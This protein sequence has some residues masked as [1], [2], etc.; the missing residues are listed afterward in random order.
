MISYRENLLISTSNI[1][2]DVHENCECTPLEFYCTVMFD[3]FSRRSHY[4]LTYRN[5]TLIHI[6]Y[7]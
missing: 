7:D 2:D 4:F 1:L 3:W 5:N 6:L